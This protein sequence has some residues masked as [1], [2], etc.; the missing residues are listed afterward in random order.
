MQKFLTT[1]ATWASNLLQIKNWLDVNLIPNWRCIKIL[2]RILSVLWRKKTQAFVDDIQM[3]MPF[4]RLNVI[5][6][7]LLQSDT[8]AVRSS[9]SRDFIW[10]HAMY[11]YLMFFIFS[12]WFYRSKCIVIFQFIFLGDIVVL[13]FWFFII[14]LT[15]GV[16]VCDSYK[17]KEIEKSIDG[18]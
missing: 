11:Y 17:I 18:T 6:Y 14:F 15:V 1:S 2:H 5:C 3:E 4:V 8:F 13:M 7:I 10:A 12:L 16:T 9:C